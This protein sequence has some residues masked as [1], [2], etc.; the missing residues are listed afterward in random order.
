MYRLVDVSMQIL[1]PANNGGKQAIYQ[2]I[3]KLSKKNKMAVFM[4]NSEDEKVVSN[5]DDIT[6]NIEFYKI[7]PAVN[8]PKK[9]LGKIRLFIQLIK[10]FYSMKPR[11]AA[12]IISKEIKKDITKNIVSFDSDVVFLETPFVAELLD[13]N[14]LRKNKIKIVLVMHNIE[15]DFFKAANNWPKLLRGIEEKR[16]QKYENKIMNLCDYIYCLSPK[17][18]Y[19]AKN[20]VEEEKIKYTPVYLE[21]PKK[22]WN[23]N[24][25]SKYVVFC[26]S[27]SF[28]PNLQGIEWFLENVFKEYIKK[29]PDIILKI[30]GKVNEVVRMRLKKY[31]NIEFTGYLSND[32]LENII[33]NSFFGVVPI[34]NGGGV[35]MKLLESISYGVPTITTKHGYEGIMFNEKDLERKPFLVANNKEEFLQ[36]MVLLT[37]KLT[38][39][40]KISKNARSFFKKVYSSEGNINNWM[41]FVK[42]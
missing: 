39:K 33:I 23:L 3:M 10:W 8:P 11:M 18:A 35:K 28:K 1:F 20:I 26:G 29:Y 2:R 4:I 31:S 42:K 12:K 41:S 37:E 22:Q 30:T 36:Y 32:D 13:F 15:K 16:I 9:K 24:C 5:I 27:L 25:N 7:Y 14:I 17:D 40:E 34:I 19:Y 38:L 21:T 6:S